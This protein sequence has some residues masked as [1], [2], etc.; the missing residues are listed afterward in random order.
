MIRERLDGAPLIVVSNREPYIHRTIKGQIVCS[1]ASGGLVSAL[2]PVIR[3][4]GGVWIAHGSGDADQ[5]VVGPD[6]TIQVPPDDPT[7]TLKRIWLSKEEVDGYYS[8]FSNGG[9]WPLCHI[10]YTRPNFHATD[11]EIYKRVNEKFAQAVLDVLDSQKIKKGFVFIQDYH[12]T[13]LAQMLKK[14]RPQLVTAQ[15]WHIPWPNPEIFR[16]CPQK[17]E[18]LQGLLSNDLLGFHL[19]YHCNNFMDTIAAEM[20]ARIDREQ[21]AVVTGGNSTLIHAFPISIDYDYTRDISASQEATT[22]R[23][24]LDSEIG[25]SYKYLAIGIDRVDYTKGIIERLCAIERFLEKYPQ[26]IGKFVYVGF[27]VISRIHINTYRN[28]NDDITR[29]IEDINW[30]FG[31]DTWHP[32]KFKRTH[33]DY[34]TMLGYYRLSDVGVVSA[35]HDGMNLVAKEYVVAQREKPGV[36]ILSSFTGASRELKDALLINPYDIESF[37]DAIHEALVMPEKE[38]QD[39]L[40][41]MKSTIKENNIYTW[42][43]NIL[44]TLV[45]LS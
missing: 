32:I 34:A 33:L 11:W 16:I 6:Q 7:Y 44:Q 31:T 23:D 35:L 40:N 22:A 29:K 17:H 2:D 39:R 5:Q 9:I 42:V 19:Q 43:A 38:K 8:G 37:A 14:K 20:E 1:R 15:F 12:L 10:A 27:G 24:T 3:A 36:L 41:R 30:R 25:M 28:L 13:L 18:I 26:Y 4:S 21:N 45:R